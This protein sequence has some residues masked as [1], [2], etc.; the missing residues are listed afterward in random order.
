MW[1]VN[2]RLHGHASATDGDPA[3]IERSRLLKMQPLL[4]DATERL[5]VA[6]SE[7]ASKWM[8]T[9]IWDQE[10]DALAEE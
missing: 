5:S 3:V 4:S 10:P 7:I 2:V 9:D 8:A 6:M 1:V